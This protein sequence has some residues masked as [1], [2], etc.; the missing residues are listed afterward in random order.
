[1]LRSYKYRLYPNKSQEKVLEQTL[2]VCCELYNAALQERNEAYKKFK[3]SINY[4]HQTSSLLE[5]K[6]YRDDVKN[7]HSQVLQDVLKRVN[8]AFQN[9]FRRIRKKENKVG[10]P[11]YKSFNRYDSFSYPQDGFKI[12][13]KYLELSYIAKIRINFI[14]VLEN[15]KCFPAII[16]PSCGSEKLSLRLK[17]LYLGEPTLFSFFL[18]LL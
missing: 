11:R 9:F 10:Y 16:I 3:K 14:P 6:E 17:D 4:Y 1:M 7:I 5:I 12:V 13:G 8:L 2:S 15:S 18:I